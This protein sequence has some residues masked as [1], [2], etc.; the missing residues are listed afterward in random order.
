[1]ES[2]VSDLFYARK[3]QL[4]G[5]YG[6]FMQRTL[7]GVFGQDD[8][9]KENAKRAMR[10]DET[11]QNN[12]RF[13]HEF[14][15]MVKEVAGDPSITLCI[16]SVASLMNE[17]EFSLLDSLAREGVRVVFVLE[18]LELND[19]NRALLESVFIVHLRTLATLGHDTSVKDNEPSGGR[20]VSQESEEVRRSR[21]ELDQA[22]AQGVLSNDTHAMLIASLEQRSGQDT[23]ELSPVA[24]AVS[25]F[26]SQGES[27]PAFKPEPV[28]SYPHGQEPPPGDDGMW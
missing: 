23:S 13:R 14:T 2:I 18:N 17:P 26:L 19:D 1:M 28:S 24:I 6:V 5:E 15:T 10:F 11:S 16:F 21:R 9:G 22:L 20:T 12:L 25:E 7:L 27:K 8:Q 3:A 4:T